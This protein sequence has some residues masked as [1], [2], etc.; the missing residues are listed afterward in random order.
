[1]SKRDFIVGALQPNGDIDTAAT[2]GIFSPPVSSAG[3]GQSREALEIDETAGNRFPASAEY[4]GRI[5]EGDIEGAARPN[6]FPFFLSMALGAPTTTEVLAPVGG[7]PGVY[8][9]VWK[10]AGLNKVPL[11]ATLWVARQDPKPNPILDQFVGAKANTLAMNVEANGYLLFTAG[12]AIKRIIENPVVPS[13]PRDSTRKWSFVSVG[14]KMAVGNTAFR[15]IDA[16]LAPV[17]LTSYSFTYGNNLVTDLYQLGSDEVVDIPEGNVDPA[18]TFTA[19]KDMDVHYR[20]ALKKTPE[21]VRLVLNAVGP[22]ITGTHKYEMGVDLKA[23]EYSAAP[24]GIDAS[25]TLRG[26][27][28]TARPVLDDTVNDIMEVYVINDQNGDTYRAPVA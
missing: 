6:S 27:E 24:A 21:Q 13:V 10:P 20:R 1:M 15:N 4:G 11:P 12:L 9:H 22:T 7:V 25:S 18:V 14:A 2:T 5:F 17:P 16:N 8:K 26:I 19:A 23:L 3:P 28:V